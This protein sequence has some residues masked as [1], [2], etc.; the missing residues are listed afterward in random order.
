MLAIEEA[1]LIEQSRRGDRLAFEQLVHR[2]AR[3]IYSRHYLDTGD[4]HRAEDLTQE[5]FLQAWRKIDQLKSGRG[6]RAWLFAVA[7]SVLLDAA[8]HD[9]RGKRRGGGGGGSRG[10]RADA[11]QLADVAN[12]GP[13]PADDAEASDEKRR[14]V[15][16]LRLM[17]EEYRLPL[18]LRYIGGADYQTI[19]GQLGLSNG[20]LRGLLQRGLAMLRERMESEQPESRQR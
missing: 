12:T 6:F 20:A 13:G 8:R 9:H 5:T 16:A 7:R 18:S 1:E 4:A 19:A 14:V 15:E 3:L 17:P 10:G 2:T 11:E